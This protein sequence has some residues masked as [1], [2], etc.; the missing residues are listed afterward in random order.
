M[1]NECGCGEN[2]AHTEFAHDARLSRERVVQIQED[3]LAHN[4]RVAL[5]NRR[6]WDANSTLCINLVSSPGAGKTTLLESTVT[7]LQ[8]R[9]P[10]AVIEGDQQT[11]RDAE[12]IGACGVPCAQINTGAGCHLDASMVEKVLGQYDLPLSSGILFIENVGNLICPSEF[13]LGEHQRVVLMSCTEGEDKPLKYP[14][15]FAT[16]TLLILTKID[17]LPFLRFDV[18]ACLRHVAEINPCMDV[19]RLSAYS[20]VGLANWI[21]W[22]QTTRLAFVQRQSVRGSP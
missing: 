2:V 8:Q 20:G 21:D 10:V 13:D 1:C 18:D 15:I 19:L 22:L 5:G 6:R 14:H 4:S 9:C 7:A 16:S 3:I 12:R 11:S 17:L